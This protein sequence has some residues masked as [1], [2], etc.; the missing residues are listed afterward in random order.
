MFLT[1]RGVR[2]GLVSTVEGV[3]SLNVR[4]SSHPDIN[5]IEA[6]LEFARSNVEGDYIKITASK[7]PFPTVCAE[8]RSVD[9]FHSIS[10]TLRWNERE[11]Q[12]SFV[13]VEEDRPKETKEK[14]P[15][16]IENHSNTNGQEGAQDDKARIK[17]SKQQAQDGQDSL[18]EKTQE[19]STRQAKLRG[20]KV[21]PQE[22]SSEEEDNEEEEEEGFDIDESV[23]SP[24]HE[25]RT[26]TNF[27]LTWQ[28]IDTNPRIH[29]AQGVER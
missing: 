19:E 20:E 14:V 23:E 21:E 13:V 12:K 25:V 27:C 24:T 2:H 22:T 6:D 9:W 17:L 29:I 5:K 26:M 15:K 11:K 10:R 1:T 18:A 16:V 28:H 7:Y 8:E 4:F 3:S